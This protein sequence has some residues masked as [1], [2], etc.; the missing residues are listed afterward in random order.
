MHG[1]VSALREEGQH[2][3]VNRRG[4]CC[5][6]CALLLASRWFVAFARMPDLF[7]RA[8][9]LLIAAMLMAATEMPMG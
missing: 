3:S 1:F 4:S 7:L 9:Y 8:K 6:S 5:R 2:D